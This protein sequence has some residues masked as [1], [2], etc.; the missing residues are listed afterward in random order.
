I[1]YTSGTTG[2]PKGVTLSHHSLTI[3]AYQAAVAMRIDHDSRFCVPMPFYHCG[4]TISSAL[5]TLSVGGTVVVPSPFFTDLPTLKA[6]ESERC[7]HVSGVPTMF[8]AQLEHP[9]FSSFDLNSLRSGFMAGAPCPVYLMKRVTSQMHLSDLVIL[10][11]LTESSPLMTATTVNDSLEIRA[12]TVGRAIPDVEVKIIDTQSDVIVERGK[13]GEICCRGHLVMLGYW[14]DQ[15]ATNEAI[16]ASGWLHSGDLGVMS[17]AGYLNITGRKKDMICRGGENVYPREI[18]EV[19]HTHESIS[20]V[21]VFGV[22]DRRLGE[23]VALWVMPKPGCLLDSDEIIVWLKARVAHFKVPRYIKVVD[24]F[25][26]TV[27]GKPRKFV[28]RDEM[29]EELGLANA[30][31]E[32]A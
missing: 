24:Q 26:L 23:E 8:I 2:F 12:T 13:Q 28:M 31:V 7:T 14:Q 3:N 32:T 16:D 15:T 30:Q 21:Q 10:Y 22:P 18:E 17:E 19:L 27:T 6:I 4:C 29:I 25:P 20:Q 5:A 1:Q 11:G 9:D